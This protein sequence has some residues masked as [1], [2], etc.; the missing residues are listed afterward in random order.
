[1]NKND[2]VCLTEEMPLTK[3][4]AITNKWIDNLHFLQEDPQ[5]IFSQTAW[6]NDRIID[7]CQRLLQQDV[8]KKDFGGFQ[9]VYL[10]QIMYFFL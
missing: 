2:P 10:V 5:I 4:Q 1:M 7:A 9:S 8:D 6:M 3:V